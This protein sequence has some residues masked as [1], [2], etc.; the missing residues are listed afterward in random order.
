[1]IQKKKNVWCWC[2]LVQISKLGVCLSLYENEKNKRN[3]SIF[4]PV[5]MSWKWIN[6]VCFKI[7]LSKFGAKALWTVESLKFEY[8]RKHVIS[9]ITNHNFGTHHSSIYEYN[10]CMAKKSWIFYST[11]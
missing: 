10:Y 7:C 11:I 8:D 5:V 6:A 3:K 2:F 4:K 9:G 1:M